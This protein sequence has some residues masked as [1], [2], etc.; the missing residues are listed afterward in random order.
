LIDHRLRPV[1][2][3]GHADGLPPWSFAAVFTS[4]DGRFTII[5]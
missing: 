1:D 4:V 3:I 2:P 5:Y